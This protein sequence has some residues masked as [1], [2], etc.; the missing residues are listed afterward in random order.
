M[1]RTTQREKARDPERK[2]ATKS[3]IAHDKKIPHDLPDKWVLLAYL[4]W[5]TFDTCTILSLLRDV[6]TTA[7]E[8]NAFWRE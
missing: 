3:E 7:H 8:I 4:F 1:H 5:M 6:A 2:I